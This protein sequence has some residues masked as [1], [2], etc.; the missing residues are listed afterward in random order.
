MKGTLTRLTSPSAS[1]KKVAQ[2]P[3]CYRDVPPVTVPSTE[4]SAP[5]LSGRIKFHPI[6]SELGKEEEKDWLQ[7]VK[8]L[9]WRKERNHHGTVSWAAYRAL[10]ATPT[11]HRPAIISLLP[12]FEER[13]RPFAGDDQ[14]FHG[15]AVHHVNPA[16]ILVIAFDQP[17]FA[18]AKQIQWSFAGTHGE[19]HFVVMLGGLHIEMT[20]YKALR[21][22]MNGSGWAEVLSTA[23]VAT[24]GVADSFITASHLTRTRRA[25]QVTAASLHLLQQ[26]AYQEY[27]S[28]VTVSDGQEL[29]SFDDWKQERSNKFPLFLYWDR[30][31]YFEISCLQLARAFR[32][33]D[34][35]LYIYGLIKIIPWMFALDQTNYARWFSVHIRDMCELPVQHQDVFQ[36]FCDGSFA[37]HKTERPFSSIALDHAH[38]QLN[39][40]LQRLA[41]GW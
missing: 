9:L 41:D 23:G 25:H 40:E 33:A 29:K 35:A 38:E 6:I 10:Q 12:M 7:N 32:E 31:L 16:Q 28:T 15:C 24:Q 3:S 22:W 8:E 37:V 34:F 36:K 5:K 19:D 20:A 14:T 39:S 17:L 30:V 13:K 26:K 1:A 2:L 18:L 21:K 27:I 4:L 11:L